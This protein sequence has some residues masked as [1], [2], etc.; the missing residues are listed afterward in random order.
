MKH[1]DYHN[2]ELKLSFVKEHLIHSL[3]LSNDISTYNFNIMKYNFYIEG[4][5][6]IIHSLQIDEIN[7]DYAVK[8]QHTIVGMGLNFKQFIFRKILDNRQN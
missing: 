4:L 6:H 5:N 8:L 3:N 2:N 7:Y 1:I